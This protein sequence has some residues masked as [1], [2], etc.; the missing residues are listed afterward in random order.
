MVYAIKDI[1]YD[2]EFESSENDTLMSAYTTN[3]IWL[4]SD[5]HN[6]E[7]PKPPPEPPPC[8]Y[9]TGHKDTW[10][11]D[12]SYCVNDTWITDESVTFNSIDV[13]PYKSYMFP[14]ITEDSEHLTPTQ[15]NTLL[16]THIHRVYTQPYSALDIKIQADGGANCSVTNNRS[17]LNM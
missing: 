16:D 11:E 3:G 17:L 13:F 6:F 7:T 2:E 10:T 4:T 5:P 12:E 1:F 15:I 8:F 9:E 14:T